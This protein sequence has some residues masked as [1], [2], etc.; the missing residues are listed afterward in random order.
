MYTEHPAYRKPEDTNVVIWRYK[1]FAEFVS[2]IES[3]SL[4][5][6]SLQELQ[7]FDPFE[8]T[9]P[10]GNRKFREMPETDDERERAE[11]YLQYEGLSQIVNQWVVSSCWHMNPSESVAMW[12][13][14]VPCGEG[15]AIRSSFDRLTKCFRE[16]EVPL[17][18]ADGKPVEMFIGEI[19]YLDHEKGF[20]QEG[21]TLHRV[22]HKDLGYTHERELRAAAIMYPEGNMQPSGIGVAFPV[23]L[24]ILIESIV[25]PPS[26]PEWIK[27]LTISLLAQYKVNV[28]VKPSKFPITIS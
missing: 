20:I 1:T 28:P 23:D 22:A 3:K 9:L 14:Y 15:V 6:A 19:N 8:G 16:G 24:E 21:N 11:F 26:C 18:R 27:R 7:Q 12:R 4:Y 17:V 5:F 25:L 13:L 10:G 2:L